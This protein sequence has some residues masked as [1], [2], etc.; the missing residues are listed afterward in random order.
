MTLAELP[1]ETPLPPCHDQS[2]STQIPV[3]YFILIQKIPPL[4]PPSQ[5]Q[6]WEQSQNLRR[7][8]K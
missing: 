1:N 7:S 2:F 4:L 6:L 3:A 5:E 8:Q